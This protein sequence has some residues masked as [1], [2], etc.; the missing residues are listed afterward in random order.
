MAL[1]L[2]VPPTYASPVVVNKGTGEASFNPI[3]LNWFLQFARVLE[4]AAAGTGVDHNALSSLQG[5]VANEYYHFTSAQHTLL[6]AYDHESLNGLLGGAAGAHYHLTAA[7][8]TQ[9]IANDHESLNG[10]LGGA[11]ADHY[12]LTGAQRTTAISGPAQAVT[13]IATPASGGTWQN[14][15]GFNVTVISTGGTTVAYS[16]SRDNITYYSV[17]TLT[18]VPVVRGDYLKLTYVGAPTLVYFAM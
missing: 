1:A 10:L 15:T 6:A 13:A 5:G 14:T 7:Q 4:N 17:G 18:A 11:A 3:W 16:I 2:P 12:H 9:V 8:R